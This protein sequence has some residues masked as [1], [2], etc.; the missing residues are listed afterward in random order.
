MDQKKGIPIPV[1]VVSIGMI[2]AAIFLYIQIFANQNSWY[3]DGDKDGYGLKSNKV[4]ATSCPPGYVDNSD[5]TNDNDK[6]IPNSLNCFNAEYIIPT[7]LKKYYT[8]LN[9][10]NIEE[11]LDF[12]HYPISIYFKQTEVSKNE[13]RQMYNSYYRKIQYHDHKIEIVETSLREVENSKR[14]SIYSVNVNLTYEYKSKSDTIGVY[15]LFVQNNLKLIIDNNLVKITE[16]TDKVYRCLTEGNK[17]LRHGKEG[18][19]DSNC[20]CVLD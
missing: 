18:K 20:K 19:I 14:D 10:Q 4:N 17:C 15:R 16:I 3:Y 11:H 9:T 1:L 7:F 2:V 13:L 5:D 6:C 12:F 8:N